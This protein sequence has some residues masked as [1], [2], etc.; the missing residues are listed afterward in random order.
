M[1]RLERRI[2]TVYRSIPSNCN[3]R[4]KSARVTSSRLPAHLNAC[5]EPDAPRSGRARTRTLEMKTSPRRGRYPSELS[6]SAREIYYVNC[7]E[8]P[9]WSVRRRRAILFSARPRRAA[10]SIN[11]CSA[12]A[13]NTRREPNSRRRLSLSPSMATLPNWSIGA[14]F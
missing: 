3:N 4:T 2:V 8:A 6:L 5:V 9:K 1:N 11:V 12:T 7:N 10:A 13:G 14:P